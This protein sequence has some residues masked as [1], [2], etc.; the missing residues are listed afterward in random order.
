MNPPPHPLVV[1]SR[2]ASRVQIGDRIRDAKTSFNTVCRRAG[3]KDFHIYVLRPAQPNQKLAEN[4]RS[5]GLVDF[6]PHS[7]K[8]EVRMCVIPLLPA[9]STME[10]EL[11]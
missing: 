11:L 1:S 9:F 8:G 7:F 6:C 2:P 4:S 5:L 3:I 10:E